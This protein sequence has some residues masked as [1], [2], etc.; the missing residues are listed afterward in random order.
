MQKPIDTTQRIN[1][2]LLRAS[3]PL[4]T[5]GERKGVQREEE[6]EEEER[7]SMDKLLEEEE[8]SQM[9]GREGKGEKGKGEKGK[10][11]IKGE[12]EVRGKETAGGTRREVIDEQT[13]LWANLIE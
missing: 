3:K 13:H 10:G 11:W 5:L 8:W 6:E 9:K 12:E 4:N 7:V 2:L 1:Q